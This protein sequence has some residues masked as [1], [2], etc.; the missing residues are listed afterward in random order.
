M[1]LCRDYRCT[2][3]EV[4]PF[5]MVHLLAE[6]AVDEARRN[7]IVLTVTQR[8]LHPLAMG[9]Y[10]TVIELRDARRDGDDA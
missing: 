5:T 4:D 7:G 3:M 1:V 6:Q 10:K 2:G 8:P 9:K